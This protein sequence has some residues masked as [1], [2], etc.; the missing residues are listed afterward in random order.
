MDNLME[1]M[2][3]NS[4]MKMKIKRVEEIA[5][6]DQIAVELDINGK[7]QKGY[8]TIVVIKGYKFILSQ[9]IL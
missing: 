2:T 5:Y 1:L 4:S 9:K 3:E 6:G 8:G 7:W